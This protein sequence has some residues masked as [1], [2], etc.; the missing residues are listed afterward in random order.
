MTDLLQLLQQLRDQLDFGARLSSLAVEASNAVGGYWARFVVE[1]T[2]ASAGSQPLDFITDPTIQKWE[3]L[4]QALADMALPPIVVAAGTVN[5]SAQLVQAAVDM[6][7]ALSRTVLRASI[8]HAD[9]VNLVHH[10]G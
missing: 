6:D 8:N 1:T 9:V 5:F 4:V 10:W 7:N 2:N 3:P